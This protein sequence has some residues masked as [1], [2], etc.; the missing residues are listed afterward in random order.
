M[1]PKDTLTE[2]S[3]L[4]ADIWQKIP[5]KEKV[6]LISRAQAHGLQVC[7]VVF[8]LA[9]AVAVG[10]KMPWAFWGSCFTLP[11]VFQ[12]ASAR[13]WG[14]VKAR[15]LVEYSAARSTACWYAK[16]V[17]ARELNPTLVFKGTLERAA[18]DG[19]A[20]NESAWAA[21]F[22]DRGPVSV[23]VTLFPD[24]IVM[25]SETPRGA[26]NELSFSLLDDFSATPEGFDDEPGAPRKIAIAHAQDGGVRNL[27]LTSEDGA[28]I[29]VCERK[30][31]IAIERRNAI[32]AE[33][34]A[35][36]MRGRSKPSQGRLPNRGAA[37]LGA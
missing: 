5:P 29:V 19:S 18:Q 25:F 12:L 30:L 37:Q 24:S 8:T 13:A 2:S 26:R 1:A 22:H 4:V 3:P 33:A 32:L 14:S 6:Y 20:V 15:V 31:Q 17:R 36:S 34:E 9:A 21:E 28:S 7:L 27:T 35:V 11:F 10:L 16:Q 23:W